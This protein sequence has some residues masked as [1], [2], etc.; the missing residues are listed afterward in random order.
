[1]PPSTP[2][3]TP[4]RR[5]LTRRTTLLGGCGATGALLLAGCTGGGERAPSPRGSAREAD[6]DVAVATEALL[7]VETAYTLARA[8]AERHPGLAE[9]LS[10]LL[11]AHGEHVAVLDDA[12]PRRATAT[13]QP[14]PS[15][16]GTA[17]PGD[18]VSEQPPTGT[19]G[20]TSVPRDER[21]A[22]S[23]VVSQERALTVQLKQLAFRA[24]SGPFARLLA[25]VA[26]S[27]AQHAA[28]LDAS[29]QDGAA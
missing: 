15:P 17:A 6:P 4:P 25:A 18:T 29:A 5:L 22:L 24:R 12:V 21:R 23:L 2:P 19:T 28:A 10:S 11:G 3:P 27:A 8:T 13:P 9:P 20:A 26:A 14:S 1:V 7:A 16:A